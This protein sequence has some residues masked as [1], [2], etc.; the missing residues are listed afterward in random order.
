MM[1]LRWGS[2]QYEGA[3]E[4]F[5]RLLRMDRQEAL[6]E[7]GINEVVKVSPETEVGFISSHSGEEE[8]KIVPIKQF[9]T[10]T[11]DEAWDLWEAAGAACQVFPD[12][13]LPRTSG[14]LNEGTGQE[15]FLLWIS[16]AF[17]GEDA[18]EVFG[19]F[20]T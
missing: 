5:Y 2:V 10:D 6:A 7:L 15:C 13:Y 16:G 18:D 19:G 8:E 11:R 1:N 3:Y 20:S 4:T 14:D 12:N 17:E 9:F